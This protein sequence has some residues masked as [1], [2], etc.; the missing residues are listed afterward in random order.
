M[1]PVH[2]GVGGEGPRREREGGE[3]QLRAV[4]EPLAHQSWR[5]AEVGGHQPLGHRPH[6]KV[7]LPRA[8]QG[9]GPPSGPTRP[10]PPRAD[11]GLTTQAAANF[12]SPSNRI[13]RRRR[14]VAGRAHP[15]PVPPP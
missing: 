15:A 6:A 9:E 5:D 2:R 7:V 13:A 10:R 14:L 4:P 11:P 12:P 1:D 3:S 8:V